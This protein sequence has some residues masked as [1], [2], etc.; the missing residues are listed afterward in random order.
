MSPDLLIWLVLTI[1]FV[2][3]PLFNPKNRAKGKGQAQQGQQQPKQQ[4]QLMEQSDRPEAT[5]QTDFE[6]KLEEARRR[7]QQALLEQNGGDGGTFSS[8]TMAP[9]PAEKPA[10]RP[11]AR[12]AASSTTGKA[13]ATTLTKTISGKPVAARPAQAQR[14]AT[15]RQKP[16]LDWQQ[17]GIDWQAPPKKY[18]GNASHAS[19]RASAERRKRLKAEAQAPQVTKADPAKTYNAGRRKAAAD[20]LFSKQSVLNGLIWHQVLSE[21]PHRRGARR[22]ISRLRSP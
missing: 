2:V 20:S 3:V 1:L 10:A 8:P 9:K 4:R 12:P 7:I 13:A 6:S 15:A 19:A 14:P 11:A 16:G 22:Q 18:S 17:S 21:P 5:G